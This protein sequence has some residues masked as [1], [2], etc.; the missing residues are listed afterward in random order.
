[1]KKL[2]RDGD[3]GM[4]ALRWACFIVM[5]RR[6]T[7][8]VDYVSAVLDVYEYAPPRKAVH[9]GGG[10]THGSSTI[11]RLTSLLLK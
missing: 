4:Q 3:A 5:N 2:E 1:M 10:G 11:I 6:H 7:K 9:S 8:S